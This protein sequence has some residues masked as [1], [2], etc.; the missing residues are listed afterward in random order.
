MNVGTL[1]G[2][3]TSTRPSLSSKDHSHEHSVIPA[4]LK[5]GY[6]CPQVNFRPCQHLHLQLASFMLE[7][8]YHPIIDVSLITTPHFPGGS[9]LSTC[10]PFVWGVFISSTC[11][12]FQRRVHI[13]D[14]FLL[15]EESPYL[16]CSSLRGKYF[17][18]TPSLSRKYSKFTRDR[19]LLNTLTTCSSILTYWSFIAPFCTIS[20]I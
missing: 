6:Y 1:H 14:L 7:H 9:I 11:S 15:S 17:Q 19:G 2:R 18:T 12:S 16:D 3:V 10:S 20:L 13:F 4:I 8:H 5:R